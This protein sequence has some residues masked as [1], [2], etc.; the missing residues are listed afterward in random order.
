[1]KEIYK[2]LLGGL[3]KVFGGTKLIMAVIELGIGLIKAKWPDLPIPDE[4]FWE[5]LA[6]AMYS[7]HSGRDAWELAKNFPKALAEYYKGLQD[8]QS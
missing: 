5:G 4:S 7:V 6:V 3:W 8:K 1:M 2:R